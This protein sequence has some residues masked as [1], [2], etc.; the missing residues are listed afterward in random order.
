MKYSR[1]TR[2]QEWREQV[3]SHHSQS[4]SA[5]Y[6]YD[7]DQDFWRGD[8]ARFRDDPFRIDDPVLSKLSDEF[9]DCSSVIDVGGGAGR[10]ALPLALTKRKV[11]VVD[12]SES[13][14]QQLRTDSEYFNIANVNTLLSLWEDSDIEPHDGVLCSHVTYGIE[15]IASFVNNLIAHA[16]RRVLILTFMDSP[17][18]HLEHIWEI[19]HEEQRINLPGA[20]E[21]MNALWYLGLT[22]DLEVIG[23][24]APHSYKTLELAK[25]D[26]RRRLYINEGD[27]KDSR[28]TSNINKQ[29]ETVADGI[30]LKYS[31]ERILCLIKLEPSHRKVAN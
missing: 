8:T 12:S 21:L 29:L 17:Q 18:S 22:P 7:P 31:P 4:K 13:M 24:L 1:K 11:T 5:Q 6:K 16:N 19:V 10:F 30:G 20:P 25:S 23:T 26:L 2:L 9:N 27:E 14:L 15:D 3:I 28:F